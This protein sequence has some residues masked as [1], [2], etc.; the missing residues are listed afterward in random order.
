MNTTTSYVNTV[1]IEIGNG[2]FTW[3]GISSYWWFSC[4]LLGF[5]QHIWAYIYSK[6][7]T[8]HSMR[9]ITGVI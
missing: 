2:T 5:S 8:L 7:T 6:Y 1:E 3:L 9:H 4:G